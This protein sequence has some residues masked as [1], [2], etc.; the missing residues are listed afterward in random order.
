MAIVYLA[1]DIRHK[2][3]V[4]LKV[5]NPEVGAVLGTERFLREVDTAAALQHPHILSVFD[6]GEA[7]GVLWYAM[8][9]VEGESLRQRLKR[10]VQL[11]V[12]EAIRI[13]REVAEALDYAHR[14]GVVHRDIK[15]DNILLAEGHALVADFGIAKAVSSSGAE[16]LTQTGMAVGT[17]AYMSP[18]QASPGA[19]LDGRSD[20]YSLGCVLYEMLAGEPPF[21]GPNSQAIIARHCADPPRSLR[22]VRPGVPVALERTVERA[23]AKVPADRFQTAGEFARSLASPEV[24]ASGADASAGSAHAPASIVAAPRKPVRHPRTLAALAV[25]VLF[26]LGVILAWL[27][28]R[29]APEMGGP[30]RLAVLPFEN[31]GRPEDAYFADGVTDEVRGK[32]AALPGLEVIARTSSVQYKETAKSLQQIGQELG[33]DYLL[34][35]TVRWDKDT[36]GENRV[37]VSPELVQVSTASTKW[38]AP[39]EA[40]LTDVFTVQAGVASR[41]AEALGLALGAGERRQLDEQ[42]T[43]NLSAYDV[44]LRGEEVSL[45]LTPTLDLPTLQRAIAS[46]ER[47]VAMDSTFALAWTQLS[48]A[49]SQ[50][51]WT[52]C[53]PEEAAAAHRSADQALALAPNRPEGYLALGDYY[54]LVLKDFAKGLEA[55]ARGQRLAPKDARLLSA[56]G[57]S[58]LY[59]GRGEEALA[60]LRQAQVLDPR[61]AD[62]AWRLTWGLLNLRLYDE[63]LQIADR[64]LALAPSN[65]DLLGSKT[66][67]Y[68]ARGDLAGA[69]AVL[70]AATRKVDPPALVAYIATYGDLSWALDDEQQRLLLRLSPEPFGGARSA[71]ALAL[72]ETYVFRGNTAQARAYA[73]SARLAYEAAVRETPQEAILHAML[74]VSLAYLGRKS[75]SI[76]EGRRAVALTRTKDVRAEAYAQHQLARIYLLAGEPERALDH[77]EPLLKIPYW[78]S[79]GWL[80]IDPNFAGLRGNPRFE[81]LIAGK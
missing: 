20:I 53:S 5:L 31:L 74:G 3:L 35:G 71:W 25:G 76:R 56:A 77:L 67:I 39:F 26:G 41:V 51:C 1:R 64:G 73:D 38:Q 17:P 68:L 49:N 24:N 14:H 23:L 28:T 54:S 45:G 8:P 32:L 79:P 60:H 72:A 52:S 13:T 50:V 19:S 33:V 22:V 11:P 80:R 57:F 21:T 70:R 40:P 62:A 10:E 66:A 16:P 46:Y 59:L 36:S 75:E 43:A 37:R 30:K 63:A 4:A 29:H 18:E 34:T 61:S 12:E 44:F 69:R 2:R 58:E 81:R 55:Y 48:R 42:P 27:Q 9:Y 65:L 78:L 7:G 15:P 6:S 47:A